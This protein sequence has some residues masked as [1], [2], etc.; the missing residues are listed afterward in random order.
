MA[1]NNFQRACIAL[2]S[3]DCVPTNVLCYYILDRPHVY[4][5][6]LHSIALMS[7]ADRIFIN[8]HGKKFFESDCQIKATYAI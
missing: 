8:K 3:I 5:S 4:F 1:R 7:A 6:N 2:K